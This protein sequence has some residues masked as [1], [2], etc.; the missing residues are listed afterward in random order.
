MRPQW[1]PMYGDHAISEQALLE[2]AIDRLPA[3][4]LM[5][6]DANFGVFSVAYAAIQRRHPVVLRLTMTGATALAKQELRDGRDRRIRGQPSPHHRRND[7]ALPVDTGVG[8]RR[9]ALHG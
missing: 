8:E 6:G 5:L 9:L 2:Q 7:P 1:G 4:S 3:D